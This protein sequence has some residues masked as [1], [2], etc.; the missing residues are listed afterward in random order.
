M[1]TLLYILLAA[2]GLYVGWW[3]LKVY[4]GVSLPLEITASAYFRQLLKKMEI[5]QI[6]PEACVVECINECI[7]AAR[8]TQKFSGPSFNVRTE[9]V[10]Q[11]ELYA[12][13]LRFWVRGEEPFVETYQAHFKAMF[14]RHSV[15]R[16]AQ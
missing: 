1:D 8:L 14:E 13:M 11:L 10:S 2:V 15:P 5:N 6:V 4:V 7:R 3:L 9:T 16:L 12:D